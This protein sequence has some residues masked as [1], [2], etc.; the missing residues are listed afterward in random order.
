[1]GFV[2][3]GESERVN[4]GANFKGIKKRTNGAKRC[5]I[6]WKFFLL[7]TAMGDKVGNSIFIKAEEIALARDIVRILEM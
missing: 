1:V 6:F 7:R 3:L 5:E 2:P 4:C